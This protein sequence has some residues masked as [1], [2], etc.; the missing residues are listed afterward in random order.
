MQRSS[1]VAF[2]S[3]NQGAYAVADAVFVLHSICCL[4]RTPPPPPQGRTRRARFR[5]L[6]VQALDSRENKPAATVSIRQIITHDE[7]RRRKDWEIRQSLP[8]PL[9]LSLILEGERKN[10]AAMRANNEELISRHPRAVRTRPADARIRAIII[11][12]KVAP[13][14]WIVRTCPHAYIHVPV[15]STKREHPDV[16]I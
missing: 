11:W 4:A 8:L 1:A 2:F 16:Q 15:C 5:Y 9:P 7:T 6:L 14:D 12:R 3:I 13:R 10:D